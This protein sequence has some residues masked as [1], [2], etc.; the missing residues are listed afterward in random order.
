MR[1]RLV[2]N[3]NNLRTS[4]SNS[5]SI[6]R[7]EAFLEITIVIVIVIIMASN[8]DNTRNDSSRSAADST[9]ISQSHN[10]DCCIFIFSRS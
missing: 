9:C 2:N 8:D 5:L 3:K 1:H 4:S 6:Y 7:G 10:L